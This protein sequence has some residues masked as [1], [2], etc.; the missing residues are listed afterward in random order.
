MTT[1]HTETDQTRLLNEAI[2][3]IQQLRIHNQAMASRL[4][5]FDSMMLLFKTQPDYGNKGFAEDIVWKLR[6]NIEEIK[7]K[8]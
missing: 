3:E 8:Q 1:T 7:S 2:E 4:D 5:V 6:K